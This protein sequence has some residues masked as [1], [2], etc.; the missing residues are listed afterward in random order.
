LSAKA[1]SGDFFATQ[2][3]RA[4]EDLSVIIEFYTKAFS[5][6]A[7]A[8]VKLSDGSEYVDF[9]FGTE[10][11]IRYFKRAGQSGSQTTSWFQQKLVNA[12]KTYMTGIK[13]CW[14]I[15]GDNHFAYDGM[16]KTQTVLDGA[17]SSN[18]GLFY[19][20]VS[21]GPAIQAYL[22]EPSGWQIQLDGQY[23]APSGTD[24]FDPEYCSTS[25]ESS[26]TPTPSPSPTPGPS[27][28]PPSPP[29]P[30]PSPTG[31][32]SKCEDLVARQ[33]CSGPFGPYG[34]AC[35]NCVFNKTKSFESAGC[36]PSKCQTQLQ[37]DCTKANVTLV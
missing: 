33:G 29:A 21:A 4:V 15:W 3:S 35:M 14:P 28:S 22:L 36:T 19:K 34:P 37:A 27:P 26:P 1:S 10:V 17:K 18:F 25:C 30:T 2:V 32:C 11:D 6:T 23:T 13:S 5:Q 12:S 20:P 24:G 9:N 31:D 16:Y 8:D 7:K